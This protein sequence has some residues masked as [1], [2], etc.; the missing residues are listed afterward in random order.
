[1]WVGD[2]QKDTLIFFAFRDKGGW[3]KFEAGKDDK[4]SVKENNDWGA[5][6]L[7]IDAYEGKTIYPD[8]RRGREKNE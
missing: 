5:G 1:M 2:K 8:R 4:D 6:V 7:A 3:Q